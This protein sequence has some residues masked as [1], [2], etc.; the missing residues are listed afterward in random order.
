MI[1]ARVGPALVALGIAAAVAVGAAAP[2][3]APGQWEVTVKRGFQTPSNSHVVRAPVSPEEQSSVFRHCVRADDMRERP[4]TILGHRKPE[5]RYERLSFA[6]GMI[7]VRSVCTHGDGSGTVTVSRG[8]YTPVSYAIT[9]SVVA[10]GRAANE[11]TIAMTGRRI[12]SICA[13]KR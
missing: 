13:A 10:T 7:D 3:I 2:T 6:A 5:C 9:G 12:S 4:E 1:T 11:T 8:T